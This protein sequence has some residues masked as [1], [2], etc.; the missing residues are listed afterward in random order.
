MSTRLHSYSRMRKVMTRSISVSPPEML[1]RRE[2]NDLLLVQPTGLIGRDQE[3][4]SIRLLLQRPDIRLLT[5]TGP[6]GVGKTRLALQVVATVGELFPAGI[7][8]I[9]LAPLKDPTL[10]ISSI[11]QEL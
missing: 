8:C 6:G 11:A 4:M 10:V 1:A 5:I 2:I 9:S 7:F 3:I